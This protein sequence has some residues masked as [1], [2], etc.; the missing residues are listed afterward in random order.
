M[1]QCPDS[2]N[3]KIACFNCRS[4]C[5]KT[6]GVLELISDKR[7]DIC[8]ITETWLTQNDSAKFAEIH[9]YGYDIL[10]APRKGRGGGVAFIFDPCSVLDLLRTKLQIILPLRF[11]N[12]SSRQ[13]RNCFVFVSCI[14]ALKFRP[15]LPINRQELLCSL[16]NST[17]I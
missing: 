11:K 12:V 7:V 10:S 8:A 17:N 14:E 1:N 2:N 4:I 5:N 3:L 16:I 6:A 15:N 13:N 9:D